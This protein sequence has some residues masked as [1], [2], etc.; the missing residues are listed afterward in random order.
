M[1]WR[2]VSHACGKNISLDNDN[3][4]A[5]KCTNDIDEEIKQYYTI[6]PNCGYIV[7]IDE[8]KIPDK[9]KEYAEYKLSTDGYSYKKNNLRSELIY[10]ESIRPCVR[11]KKI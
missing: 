8:K 11:V 2:N 4:F 1:Y 7:L 6:C 5:I 9:I 10:L 3:V